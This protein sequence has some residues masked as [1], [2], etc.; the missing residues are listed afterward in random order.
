MWAELENV[1]PLL[2]RLGSLRLRVAKAAA[3]GRGRD[4]GFA[5]AFG[6][7]DGIAVMSG[8]GSAVTGRKGGKIEN[9]GG[10]GHLL[11]DRG[12]A[13]IISIEGLRL[14]LRDYDLE[15]RITPLAESILRA[16]SL[17]RMEDLIGWTQ[18]ADKREISALVPVMFEIAASGDRQMIAVIEA[19][20]VALA[21][22]TESVARWLEFTL[23]P[24]KLLGSLFLHQPFYVD[25]YRNALKSLIK[26][27]SLEVC[28]VSGAFGA[29]YLAAA[30]KFDKDNI[31]SPALPVRIPTQRMTA[32]ERPNPRSK[33]IDRLPLSKLIALFIHEEECIQS[34]LAAADEPLQKAVALIV[35]SFRKDGRLFYVGAGTSGRLGILDASEIPPTFG[36]PPSR[37]QGIIAGGQRAITDSVEGAEDDEI[38]GAQSVQERGVC[39]AD[40]VC[41]ITA[42]GRTPFVL[43][44]LREAR[45]LGAKTILLT[46]NP[47]AANTNEFGIHL[48]LRTG[49]ELITGSTR[50]KCGTATK[51]A[52][53]ILTTCSMIRLGKVRGNE[54]VDLQPSN[55]KLKNRAIRILS[56]LRGWPEEK[57][58]AVLKKHRWNIRRAMKDN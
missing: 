9:A 23:P 33:K 49:P 35:Q 50:L 52:L 1:L 36:E 18:G 58:G 57:A 29:A 2:S 41:G 24:V 46:C 47:D 17:N 12:G 25:L 31:T 7:S 39:K 30:I 10:R 27:K 32:T 15:H 51:A 34:A 54:M 3:V 5:A 19:G 4:S 56:E 43:S 48:V 26:I 6:D 11:G 16:L 55:S 42:S 14:A 44:A 38:Q 20:A 8:T 13:Y 37:V 28:T 53:N 40:V 21:Q 45:R 22:Y